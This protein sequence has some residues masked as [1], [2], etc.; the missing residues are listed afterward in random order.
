[1]FFGERI[2]LSPALKGTSDRSRGLGTASEAY[3]WGRR[4]NPSNP[5]VGLRSVGTSEAEG[6]AGR[7]SSGSLVQTPSGKVSASI[8]Q[9]SRRLG[10]AAIGEDK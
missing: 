10:H 1:M 4:S 5:L 3:P 2:C 7:N 8:S 9:I 6:R